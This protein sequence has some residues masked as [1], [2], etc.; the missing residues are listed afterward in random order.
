MY[1]FLVVRGGPLWK[2]TR[3]PLEDWKSMDD[4]LLKK[5]V[6][7]IFRGEVLLTA[8]IEGGTECSVEGSLDYHAEE[9]CRTYVRCTAF[10]Y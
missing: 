2:S 8:C 10:L 6:L 3:S 1:K 4:R 5:S 7:P 9:R